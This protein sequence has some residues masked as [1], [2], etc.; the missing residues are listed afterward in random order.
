MYSE[1]V[2]YLTLSP[3]YLFRAVLVSHTL[4]SLFIENLLR[5]SRSLF[6]IY[7]ELFSYLTLSPLYLLRAVFV[8]HALSSLFIENLLRISHSLLCIYSEPFSYSPLYQC[9]QTVLKTGHKKAKPTV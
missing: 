2:S 4:S 1:L 9:C 5:I 6:Y 3:L 8:S 7:S